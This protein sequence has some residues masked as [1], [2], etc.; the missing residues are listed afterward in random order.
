MTCLTLCSGQTGTKC[1]HNHVSSF[2]QLHSASGL[3][4]AVIEVESRED[5]WGSTRASPT[6]LALWLA[7]FIEQDPPHRI[8]VWIK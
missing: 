1:G 7:F 4:R 6:S 2:L 8:V 3:Q 5:A